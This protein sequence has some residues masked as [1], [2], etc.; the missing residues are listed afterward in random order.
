LIEKDCGAP[1]IRP[2]DLSLKIVG[3]IESIPNRYN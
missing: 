3:G 1:A 2:T